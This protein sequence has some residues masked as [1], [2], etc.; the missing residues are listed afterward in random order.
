MEIG[1]DIRNV[2]ENSIKLTLSDMSVIPGLHANIF[3]MAWALQKGFQV[4]S[5]CKYVILN[6]NST[7]I[8]FDEK[9]ANNGGNGFILS[10][11]LYNIP[12]NVALL[13]PDK[14]KPKGKTDVQPEGTTGNKQ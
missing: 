2:T 7:E 10:T 8:R 4:T 11:N 13:V 12:K 5:E 1:M 6:K 14:Q 9:M 3:S